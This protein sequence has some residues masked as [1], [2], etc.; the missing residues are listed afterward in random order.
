MALYE[1]NNDEAKFLQNIVENV[2]FQ[3][4]LREMEN[5]I[6]L[7]KRVLASLGRPIQPTNKPKLT[8]QAETDIKGLTIE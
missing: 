2:S 1:L 6:S 5:N 7:G 8:K 4:K 3:G